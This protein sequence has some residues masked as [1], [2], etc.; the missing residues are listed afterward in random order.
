MRKRV[1]SPGSDSGP[2]ADHGSGLEEQAEYADAAA[3]VLE[4]DVAQLQVTI[5]TE[6]SIHTNFSGLSNQFELCRPILEV[7]TS[8]CRM[9]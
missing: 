2:E 6:L 1:A 9:R 7:F 4:A 8:T 5:H 3:A